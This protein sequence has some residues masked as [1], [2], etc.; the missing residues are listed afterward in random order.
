[1]MA[2]TLTRVLLVIRDKDEWHYMWDKLAK[3]PS[4]RGLSEPTVAENFGEMWSYMETQEVGSFWLG[5]RRF[6]YFRH[7]MHP[8]K[9][10]E[11]RVRIPA[12]RHFDYAD[13]VPHPFFNGEADG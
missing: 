4:N 2:K 8:T 13:C 3:H 10:G 5:K 6:H 12:S 11:Y 9:I 1:M 7:R